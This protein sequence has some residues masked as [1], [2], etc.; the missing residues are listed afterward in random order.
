[1]VEKLYGPIG[2]LSIEL[3]SVSFWTRSA[4]AH[5]LSL[6]IDG[7]VVETLSGSSEKAF[8]TM[9]FRVLDQAMTV[10]KFVLR[11]GESDS[12]ARFYERRADDPSFRTDLKLKNEAI[13][14]TFGGW[15]HGTG[16]LTYGTQRLI[17][18]G[19]MNVR[20]E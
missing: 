6:P 8:L 19:T 13:V 3:D 5:K 2:S 14:G 18:I 17:R 20:F 9:E 15:L 16:Q 11:I 7:S 4:V 12:T 10:S 1:V